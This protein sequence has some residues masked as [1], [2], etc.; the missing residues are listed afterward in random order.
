MRGYYNKPQ[1]SIRIIS[2]YASW[3]QKYLPL[4]YNYF[5]CPRPTKSFA[6]HLSSSETISS[7]FIRHYKDALR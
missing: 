3:V 2:S 5:L 4:S 1:L 6:I 7:P